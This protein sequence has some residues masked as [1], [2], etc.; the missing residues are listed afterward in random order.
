M[1]NRKQSSALGVGRLLIA[2]YG[3]LATAASVRAL[4][5]L[6]FKF[7]DAPI[8][9]SLSALSALVYVLATIALAR[10][11]AS[12][13]WLSTAKVAVWFELVGVVLVG[14]LSILLPALFQHASVWSLYGIGYGFV[15]L[16]LP[17]LGLLWLRKKGA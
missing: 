2:V 10:S 4:Y 12:A 16:V 14:T 9:Y 8:A 11:K 5:Q 6:V 17:V 3:I 7:Q 15:P 13:R 1:T